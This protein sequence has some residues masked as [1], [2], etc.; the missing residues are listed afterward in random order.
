M[1]ILPW[2]AYVKEPYIKISNLRIDGEHK[3]L[4]DEWDETKLHN[5][6]IDT[7]LSNFEITTSG[8]TPFETGSLT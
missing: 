1:S 4:R 6:Y 8:L 2:I 5:P 7:T 3:A